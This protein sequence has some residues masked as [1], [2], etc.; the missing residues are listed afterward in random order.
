M[1]NTIDQTCKGSASLAWTTRD[2][3]EPL[4]AGLAGF[5]LYS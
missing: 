3:I 1:S 4:A 2:P 5:L